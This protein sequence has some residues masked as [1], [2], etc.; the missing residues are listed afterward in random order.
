MALRRFGVNPQK[1]PS[2]E[3]TAGGHTIVTPNECIGHGLL[4]G[5]C[6]MTPD[7]TIFLLRTGNLVRDRTAMVTMLTRLPPRHSHI[8]RGAVDGKN[9]L[10]L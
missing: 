7:G 6:C 2:E 4:F 10:M 1:S 3:L 5:S 8:A 9:D